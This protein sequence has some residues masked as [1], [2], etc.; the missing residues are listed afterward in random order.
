MRLTRIRREQK[1]RA[2]ARFMGSYY[3]TRTSYDLDVLRSKKY[4]RMMKLQK[5]ATTYF[6]IQERKTLHEQIQQIDSVLELR[7]LRAQLFDL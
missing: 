5:E 3:Q 6:N 1:G 4:L 2:M 7:M